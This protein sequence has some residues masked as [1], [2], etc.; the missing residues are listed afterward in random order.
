[1]QRKVT[2]KVPKVII[3]IVAFLFGVIIARLTYV[4]LSNNIDGINLREFAENRNTKSEI[5]Y[6]K[7][8]NIYDNKGNVLAST[9][10][11]YTIVA[12][13]EESRTTNPNKPEHVVDKERTAKALNEVLGID[14]DYGLKRLN[15]DAYEVLFGPKGNDVSESEKK[16]LE[17]LDLPGID[18]RSTIKRTYSMG[19][20]ASYIIGYAKTNEDGD[21]KGELGIE[22]YF[23]EEL[24]G[25]DG[26]TTY[27]T[28]AYGYT[29]P[30]AEVITESAVDG[31]DIYLTIDR[32]IQ[33][34]AEDLTKNLADNYEMDWMIFSVMDAKTGAIVASSTSPNFDPNKLNIIS[35]MNPLVSYAYEPGST[36]KIFSFASSIEEGKY[37][38]DAYFQSGKVQVDSKVVIS[39]FNKQ[40]WG[41]IKYDTGFA[42]SSNVAAT[43]LALEL[44]VDNLTKYYKNLGFSKKTGIELANE[45]NGK[46]SFQYKSE[47]ATASFGQ[48]I[49]VT[50]IQMLQALTALTNDGT[51]L[52]PYIVDK[53]VNADGEVIYDGKRTEVAKVYSKET[54]DY[55][56][57]LMHDVV[58]DGLSKNW[59]PSKTTMIGK[60]GTAQ[61][62]SSNGGYLDGAY[63]YIRS[64]AGVFPED[65]PQYIVYIAA[66]QIKSAD[67]KPLAKELTKVVD[68]IVSYIGI[69]QSDN[70]IEEKII[71][72]NN[73]IS[74]EIVATVEELKEK[75]INV[76]V[77]GTGKYV[78]NQYPLKK[79]K[80]QENGKVFLVSN[81]TDFVM[82]DLTGWSLSE[83][84]T[85]TNLLGIDLITN[86]Y[87]YVNNQNI[88]AGTKITDTMS[89][90]IT[91]NEKNTIPQ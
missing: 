10:N 82:E 45:V 3:F 89:L 61:I 48:G 21:I 63:D 69:E 24:S 72:L 40:G 32:R 38:G 47:L 78:I 74:T 12:Y 11:T 83:V 76:Y 75:K 68:D 29:L 44:G 5:I 51:V 41:E 34:F 87:G 81:N 57:N 65:D 28:D 31:N 13:L 58:Y 59:Q 33:M 8:G 79:S 53:I 37:D 85:Y 22:S 35:Y 67:A 20:F 17:L 26:K 70:E 91:L 49:T 90:T 6:A 42:Y 86:G 18:F 1:M 2:V 19:S 43:N 27:Q 9:A 62:A 88:V 50:P 30:S 39:D 4:S 64:F 71:N 77:L 56:K 23:D 14:Y 60:T 46:I 55:I 52:K 36:M 25:I 15:E 7:R 80:V 16:Q 54:M 84:M 73:Y 66:K